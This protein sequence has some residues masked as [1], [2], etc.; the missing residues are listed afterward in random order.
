MSFRAF[1]V[2][3]EPPAEA[4]LRRLLRAYPEIEVVGAAGSVAQAA[5]QIA[6]VQ[7]ELIFLDVQLPDG[8]GF[9]LLRR[10]PT[11]IP[12][13]FTTAHDRYALAA[14]AATSLDYLLK[15]V[16]AEAL[17]RAV[18]KVRRFLGGGARGELESQVAALLA[19]LGGPSRS[20]LRRI[21]VSLG[22]RTLLLDVA[23]VTHFGAEDK[24]VFAHTRAGKSHIVDL[25]LDELEARLDP[26]AFLRVHRSTIV[27]L[28]H[29]REIQRW[30]GSKLRVL[31][32]D[33]AGTTVVASK[34]RAAR[35]RQRLGL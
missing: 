25:T 9:E 8:D 22:E 6:L 32:A 21:A 30:F 33:A 4:R 3:D 18:G 2:E 26:E 27:G 34:G 14:F 20:P 13:V 1:V 35:I 12:V 17:A 28:A 10:L 23:D 7:P 15:P 24:Y 11:P 29:V 16:E 19:A 5:T 31:L